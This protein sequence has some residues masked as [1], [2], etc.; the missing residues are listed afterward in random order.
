MTD[1]IQINELSFAAINVN[2]IYFDFGNGFGDT[3]EDVSPCVLQCNVC[4]ATYS[5]E[6][7][8]EDDPCPDEMC[9]N[10][11]TL[12]RP[13]CAPMMNY[14]YPLP[15]Y[16]GD[17][18][19]DQARLYKSSANVVLVKIIGVDDDED[20]YA[21]ALSGG[22]MDLSWDICQAFILLGYAPPLQFCDLPDFA[23]QD[24]SKEPFWSI[25]KACLQSAKAAEQRAMR[26]TSQLYKQVNDALACCE[27]GHPD[28]HN[29][30]GGCERVEHTLLGENRPKTRCVCMRESGYRPGDA[31]AVRSM[32]V[33]DT[34]ALKQERVQRAYLNRLAYNDAQERGAERCDDCGT[35]DPWYPRCEKH[36][37]IE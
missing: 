24:N 27:C 18:G 23:G 37:P 28:P 35:T 16:E 19:A 10:D 9:D 13:D 32:A 12:E 33:S 11:G 31:E 25:L 30:M 15:Y 21:L 26:Q 14:Y 4:T 3:W 7:Y 34:R 29:R 2:S 6:V 20:V 5:D 17:P 36:E 22:G 8:S 1:Q